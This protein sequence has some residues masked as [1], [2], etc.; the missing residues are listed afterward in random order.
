ME[1]PYFKR[2]GKGSRVGYN[3]I[4]VSRTKNGQYSMTL[5]KNIALYLEI[6]KGSVIHFEEM[7]KIIPSLTGDSKEERYCI[8]K[9]SDIA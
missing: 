7:K 5:P 1:N 9:K 2:K 4:K 8:L 6:G 3:Y